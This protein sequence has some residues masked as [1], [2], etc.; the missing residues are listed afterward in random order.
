MSRTFHHGNHNNKGER[1]IRVKGLRKEHPD[2][3][4]I[5]RAIIEFVQ[6]Q[7]EA[8]AEAQQQAEKQKRIAAKQ[9]RTH[10]PS[11]KRENG[12]DA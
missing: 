10:R 9:C 5:A 2:L 6:M 12:G 8:E 7:A 4:R 3:R 1:R 11:T